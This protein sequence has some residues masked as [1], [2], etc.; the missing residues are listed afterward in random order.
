MNKLNQFVDLSQYSL[1]ISDSAKAA[2]ALYREAGVS[3]FLISQLSNQSVLVSPV[4][5]PTENSL[6]I[7]FK[8][9]LKSF[10][11]DNNVFYV[12]QSI[13]SKFRGLD[14]VLDYNSQNSRFEF[15]ER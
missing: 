15:K 11:I 10:Y 9:N 5:I 1:Y 3:K 4:Y 8:T 6:K 2:L 13:F 14:F 7:I 12:I